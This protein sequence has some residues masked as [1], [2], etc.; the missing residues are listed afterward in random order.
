M[1]F[2]IAAVL[3][4][5]AAALAKPILL[6]SNYQIEEDTPFTLKWSNAQGPVTVTLMTGNDPNNLKKVSDLASKPTPLL[7]Y[8]ATQNKC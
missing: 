7:L 5:A 1:K 6:N 2:S 8:H 4:Y 3:A